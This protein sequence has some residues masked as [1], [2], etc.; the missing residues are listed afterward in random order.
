LNSKARMTRQVMSLRNSD[1]TTAVDATGEVTEG[2]WN[3]AP[4]F[5]EDV[6]CE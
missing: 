2:D 6:C 3:S 5:G 4:D 1:R